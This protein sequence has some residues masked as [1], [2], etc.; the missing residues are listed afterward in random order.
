MFVTKWCWSSCGFG[1]GC[2]GSCFDPLWVC[3]HTSKL[4]KLW[5]LSQAILHSHKL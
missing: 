2:L 5:L 4:L 1:L 3:V